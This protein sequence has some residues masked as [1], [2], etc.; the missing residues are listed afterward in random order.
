L[1]G[2]L[3]TNYADDGDGVSGQISPLDS[4]SNLELLTCGIRAAEGRLAPNA[5]EG[6]AHLCDKSMH[7][8]QRQPPAV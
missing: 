8:T 6:R 3:K 7:R 4:G 2:E 5:E 1:V